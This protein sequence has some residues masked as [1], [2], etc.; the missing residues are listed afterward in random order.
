[1]LDLDISPSCQEEWEKTQKFS[2]YPTPDDEL[3]EL[4]GKIIKHQSSQE[5]VKKAVIKLAKIFDVRINSVSFI[6]DE[7]ASLVGGYDKNNKSIVFNFSNSNITESQGVELLTT[8]IHE[9]RHAQQS[10]KLQYLDNDLG[11]TIHESIVNYRCSTDSIKDISIYYTNFIEIDAE[12]FAHKYTHHL[13]E[14]VKAKTNIPYS[15]DLE[16]K[17]RISKSLSSIETSSG[18]I[19]YNKKANE[20]VYSSFEKYMKNVLTNKTL[21]MEQKNAIAQQLFQETKSIINGNGKEYFGFTQSNLAYLQDLLYENCD[22][23]DILDNLDSDFIKY[24]EELEIKFRDY[25]LSKNQ[26]YSTHLRS[27]VTKCE[28]LLMSKKIPFD[29]SKPSETVKKAFEILPNTILENIGKP[30]SEAISKLE[31]LL[32]SISVYMPK[33]SKNLMAYT[34]NLIEENI[35][36]EKLAEFLEKNVDA[37]KDIYYCGP[38]DIDMF[39]LDRYYMDYRMETFS[40][41]R[42]KL[43]QMMGIKYTKGNFYE[44]REKFQ[45]NFPR[46]LAK[47]LFKPKLTGEE[48][49]YITS[50]K[51]GSFGDI[52]VKILE[53]E[54]R[55]TLFFQSKLSKILKE[56]NHPLI[57]ALQS[58][59]INLNELLK[60]KQTI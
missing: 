52:D 9:L 7:K 17:S 34:R 2:F 29:K 44:I 60:N 10:Q 59:G 31:D 33:Q 4:L 46:F 45:E 6:S 27:V 55:K 58:K 5:D 42:E 49:G 25:G 12:T 32:L 19:H 50:Y 3:I 26:K 21:T 41:S 8:I 24:I 47:C 16:L 40:N 37:D 53:K 51:Y 54:I 30:K 20:L 23:F 56:N 43:L 48:K 11:K 1:M 36:R 35:P 15:A 14:M 38:Y 39:L 22:P 13:L 28:Y 57:E 18:L